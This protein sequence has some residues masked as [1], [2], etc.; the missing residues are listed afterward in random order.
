VRGTLR[1]LAPG[2]PPRDR[3]E[4]RTAGARGLASGRPALGLIGLGR[5]RVRRVPADEQGRMRADR[6]PADVTGPAVICAQ[7][8]EVNTGAFDPF[9]DI[10]A[11]ARRRG[12]WVHVDG[13]FGLWALADPARIGLTAGL[14]DADSWATDAHKWLNVPYDCG[15]V[16]ARRPGD[17]RRSF[18]GA[19]GYLPPDSGFEAMHHTPQSS[20]RARQVEVW[21]V[22]RTLGRQ[23]VADL[24]ARSCDHARAMAGALRQAGL[25]VLNDVV[26]NQVLVRAGTDD[27]TLAMVTAVRQDGTCW[28]GPTAWDGRPAMRIS[29]SCWA[30]TADDIARSAAAIAGAARLLRA[31]GSTRGGGLL[32]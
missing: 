24:V 29:V 11:W 19:A 1:F 13:A 20:Q 26:L 25:E 31:A 27:R 16:L 12:A 22:L 28:C 23:G 7:A 18:A 4:A 8:G 14:A 30:T 9:G 3:A 15:I 17:L 5:E 21:A 6:L 10:V 32:R 2:G